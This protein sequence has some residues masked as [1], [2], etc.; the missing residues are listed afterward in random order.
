MMV[1]H[2]TRAQ[3]NKINKTGLGEDETACYR[4]LLTGTRQSLE[5]PAPET[6]GTMAFG[7]ESGSNSDSPHE[8]LSKHTQ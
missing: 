3:R 8:S 5:E 4:E 7:V 6:R 1:W 2:G